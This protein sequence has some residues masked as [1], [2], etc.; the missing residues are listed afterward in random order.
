M[1]GFGCHAVR[2]PR[3]QLSR[4]R[5]APRPLRLRRTGPPSTPR[6]SPFSPRSRASSA[7]GK[8]SSRGRPHRVRRPAPRTASCSSKHLS[9]VPRGAREATLTEYLPDG[10]IAERVIKLDPARTPLQRCSALPP[11]QAPHPRRRRLSRPARH[12]RHREA[13]TRSEARCPHRGT[14]ARRPEKEKDRPVARPTG[15]LGANAGGSG[16]AKAPRQ[17]HPE[18]Q[19]RPTASPLA[20]RPRRHGSARPDPL[21]KGFFRSARVLLDAACL[22]LHHSEL[23]GSPRRVSYVPSSTFE[24][25]R[26]PGAVTFSQEKTSSCVSSR[27]AS[28][29]ARLEHSARRTRRV[30]YQGF[31]PL[32][33]VLE[34]RRFVG[35]APRGSATANLPACNASSPCGLLRVCPVRHR[36]P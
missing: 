35:R 5:A 18:L 4:S 7:P 33:G 30:R 29:T 12:P 31:D 26:I 21:E 2:P 15:V 6:E 23:K 1:N 8:K 20:P 34:P 27:I 28:A 25:P 22:A 24:G 16:S 36:F 11:V 19:A 17:R 10:E 3:V 14:S 13:C 9:Q 32:G